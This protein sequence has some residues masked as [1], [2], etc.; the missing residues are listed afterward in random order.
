MESNSYFVSFFFSFSFLF[1]LI[2]DLFS[3]H[4]Q[5]QDILHIDVYDKDTIKNDKIGSSIIDLNSLY[6]KSIYN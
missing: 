4:L 1:Q 2:F 6:Q 5:G 3:N